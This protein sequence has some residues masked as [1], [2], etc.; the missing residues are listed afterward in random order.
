MCPAVG[1]LAMVAIWSSCVCDSLTE[2]PAKVIDYV[3]LPKLMT[4]PSHCHGCS[5]GWA[6]RHEMTL[7]RAVKP[8]VY[9]RTCETILV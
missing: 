8:C 5:R 2:L 1:W 4:F 6:V 7:R 9:S 3:F